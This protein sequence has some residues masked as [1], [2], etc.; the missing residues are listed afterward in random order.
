M[1]WLSRWIIWPPVRSCMLFD[2][3]SRT[4]GRFWAYRRG[5]KCPFGYPRP[6]ALCSSGRDQ[7]ATS[8]SLARSGSSCSQIFRMAAPSPRE[9]PPPSALPALLATHRPPSSIRPALGRRS[10]PLVASVTTS[11]RTPPPALPSRGVSSG[12]PGAFAIGSPLRPTVKPM[13]PIPHSA[14]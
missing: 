4:L 9:L 3:L 5:G 1:S 2:G 8:F 6:A 12:P 13:E 7:T 14:S 10:S 11:I